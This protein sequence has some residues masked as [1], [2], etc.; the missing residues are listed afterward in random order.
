MVEFCLS[1]SPRKLCQCILTS[2]KTLRVGVTLRAGLFSPFTDENVKMPCVRPALFYLLVY[3][4]ACLLLD[5]YM[6]YVFSIQQKTHSH[7]WGI[8][9]QKLSS[10]PHR[11]QWVTPLWSHRKQRG[12]FSLCAQTLPPQPDFQPEVGWE[13]T[14]SSEAIKPRKSAEGFYY[15]NRSSQHS[16][17]PSLSQQS[18]LPCSVCSG[19]GWPVSCSLA[20]SDLD[21]FCS[22]ATFRRPHAY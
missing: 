13:T 12:T 18:P 1:V 22:G 15:P 17:L 4:L 3:W 16:T 8:Q 7:L 5:S 11:A 6:K 9:P 10:W 21:F 2:L 14:S 19:G 20:T